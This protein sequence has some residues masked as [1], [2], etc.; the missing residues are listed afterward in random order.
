[1]PV[2]GV[3]GVLAGLVPGVVAGVVEGAVAPLVAGAP[4][5]LTGVAAGAAGAAGREVSGV[6]SGGSG[7]VTIP[8]TNSV[9]PASE[10][11]LRNLYHCMRVS[12][13]PCLA[14]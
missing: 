4:E 8:A 2:A 13:Q 14:P 10:L 1:M 5:L 7:L 6:G 12:F 3:V 9:K 11:L